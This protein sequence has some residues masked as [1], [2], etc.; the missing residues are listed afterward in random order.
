M[1]RYDSNYYNMFTRVQKVLDNHVNVWDSHPF[2]A[3]QKAVFDDYLDRIEALQ[4]EQK[5]FLLGH[6]Q[7]KERIKRQLRDEAI[8]LQGSL[9]VYAATTNNEVLPARIGENKTVIYDAQTDA[10]L[11]DMAATIGREARTELA[12]LE[13]FT[14]T[15][16]YLQGYETRV[17]EY[18]VLIG[19][20]QTDIHEL[21]ALKQEQSKT[22]RLANDL[23]RKQFD[24]VILFLKRNNPQFHE[25]FT[26]ARTIV[27]R[28]ARLVNNSTETEVPDNP[29]ETIG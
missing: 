27:N 11:L 23:L 7:K 26:Q 29:D 25:A 6:A 28:R 24:P 4:V 5:A 13:E 15:E 1:N 22:V 12:Q 18:R 16:E 9:L 3:R 2:L 19:Q 20:P 10:G 8:A 21:N 17:A 14:I